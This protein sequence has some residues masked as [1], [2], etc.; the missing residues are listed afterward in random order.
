MSGLPWATQPDADGNC[1]G[2]QSEP[3]QGCSCDSLP[4]TLSV[5]VSGLS[6]LGCVTPGQYGSGSSVI[7]S[8]SENGTYPATFS[9]TMWIWANAAGSSTATDYVNPDCTGDSSDTFS[10]GGLHGQI[11]CD[12][13]MTLTVSCAIDWGPYQNVWKGTGLLNEPITLALDNI[14]ATQLFADPTVTITVP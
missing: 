12:E 13:G 6:S 5:V 2:C 3:C 8:G 14:Y 9:S 10:S 1:C 4:A 11:V 7:G